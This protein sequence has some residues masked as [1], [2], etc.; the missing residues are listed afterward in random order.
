MMA[1]PTRAGA[2]TLR[3]ADQRA[4]EIQARQIRGVVHAI[5]G[6]VSAAAVCTPLFAQTTPPPATPP[7]S[8][9]QLQEVTVTGIRASLQRAMDIKEQA[10]GVVDAISSEDIG[11][12]P[13]ANIGDALA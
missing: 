7:A 3:L 13:D 4:V 9:D 10:I 1:Q 11:Q 2:G 12:F 5:L 8:N 6:G